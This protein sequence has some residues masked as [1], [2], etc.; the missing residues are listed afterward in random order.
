M[1]TKT[2][3]TKN[4]NSN[5]HE[6]T[7]TTSE[8][9]QLR[10]IV[11]GD[12]RRA[13]EEQQQNMFALLQ[14]KITELGQNLNNNL[15]ES[16]AALQKEIQQVDKKA[17]VIDSDH[18]DRADQ[19]KS[20]IEQLNH[21]LAEHND[22]N[23]RDLQQLQASISENIA[24]LSADLQQQIA[25]LVA[26]LTKMSADLDSSKTDRKQL[27]QLFNVVALNLEQDDTRQSTDK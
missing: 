12:A 14:Q 17:S 21:E 22:Q 2:H 19:L 13:L 18:H 10:E 25:K 8:L 20:E 23:D 5:T 4:N 3:G 9:A 7:H 24:T 1:S 6:N 26:D 15:D 27:A 16:F 11:F